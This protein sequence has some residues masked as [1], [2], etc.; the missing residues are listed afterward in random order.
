[1]RTMLDL[2][3]ETALEVIREEA[4]AR[5]VVWTATVLLDRSG[6]ARSPVPY[7]NWKKSARRRA[8]ALLKDLWLSRHLVRRLKPDTRNSYLAGS[9]IAYARPGDVAGPYLVPC[10]KCSQ[11]CEVTSGL[12]GACDNGCRDA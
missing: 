6:L 3:P 1:M 9:E 7:S 11:P 8:E 4:N 5:R 2:S 10:V 12:E